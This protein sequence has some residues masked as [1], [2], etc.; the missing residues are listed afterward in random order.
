MLASSCLCECVLLS[1]CVRYFVCNVS[2]HVSLS[3]VSLPAGNELGH[4]RCQECVLSFAK[5][6]FLTMQVFAA[7]RETTELLID[8]ESSTLTV[9][10]PRD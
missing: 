1:V 7:T 2:L 4:G 10:Y 5:R 6:R 3:F 9:P 8:F